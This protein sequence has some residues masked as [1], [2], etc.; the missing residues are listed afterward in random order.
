MRF[1]EVPEAVSYTHLVMGMNHLCFRAIRNLSTLFDHCS[2]Q[3]HILVKDRVFHK[4][5]K[6]QIFFPS[7]GRTHIRAEKSLDP[8]SVQ[9]FFCLHHALLR[10]VKASGVFFHLSAIL[11]RKLSCIGCPD[12]RIIKRLHQLFYCLLY[13]SV[14]YQTETAGYIPPDLFL[15]I[16]DRS[17]V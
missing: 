15:H 6:L 7:P 8:K 4:S 10:I 1:C 16:S 13:T 14:P 3:D 12:F 11:I 5:T 9:I 2:S 17:A